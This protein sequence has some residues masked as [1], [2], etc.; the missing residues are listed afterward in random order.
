MVINPLSHS[1]KAVKIQGKRSK[2]IQVNEFR[3]T[4]RV[5]RWTLP[6]CHPMV[7]G[8]V[9]STPDVGV[10]SLYG[11][12]TFIYN[13]FLG[14]NRPLCTLLKAPGSSKCWKKLSTWKLFR[15]METKT[16]KIRGDPLKQDMQYRINVATNRWAQTGLIDQHQQR[17]LFECT[18]QRVLERPISTSE[19]RT[20]IAP[21]KQHSSKPPTK[22]RN[23]EETSV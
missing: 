20:H 7:P 3:Y 19:L 13:F 18:C 22:K 9:Q 16:E 10:S 21:E 12:V 8:D 17:C 14:Y 6:P 5:V 4:T 23:G 15:L 2:K 11:P 1:K